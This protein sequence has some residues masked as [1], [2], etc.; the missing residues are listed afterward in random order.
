[1][2]NPAAPVRFT[3]QNAVAQVGRLFDSVEGFIAA[4]IEVAPGFLDGENISPEVIAGKLG[5]PEFAFIAVI[6]SNAYQNAMDSY[7]ASTTYNLQARVRA[8]QKLVE[9]ATG[10]QKLVMSPKGDAVYVDR[11]TGEVIAADKHL[12]SLQS[13]PLETSKGM[14]ASGITIQFGDTR[15]ETHQHIHIESNQATSRILPDTNP[16]SQDRTQG[17][18]SFASSPR[19]LDWG[20]HREGT[21]GDAYPQPEQPAGTHSSEAWH[22][23]EHPDERRHHPEQRR[24]MGSAPHQ[25]GAGDGEG[26]AGA[27][28]PYRAPQPGSGPPAG[29]ARAYARSSSGKPF[30]SHDAEIVDEPVPNANGERASRTPESMDKAE[31]IRRIGYGLH[32]TP[33]K[34]S[35]ARQARGTD[36]TP[37]S[38]FHDFLGGDTPITPMPKTQQGEEAVEATERRARM[39]RS[40][41]EGKLRRYL[42]QKPLVEHDPDD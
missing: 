14:Q 42:S 33:P 5:I 26:S 25:R 12:R 18:G 2:N 13:R 3:Q 21:D 30:Q 7:A 9:V 34:P 6:N 27:D 22:H 16:A 19:T 24:R 40:N 41:R 31:R 39:H 28:E 20:A 23:E 11:D 4:I 8:M 32:Q 1:M 29:Q 17:R 38:Q 35:E 36:E 15:E 10:G 37:G